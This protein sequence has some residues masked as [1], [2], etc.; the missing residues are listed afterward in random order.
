MNITEYPAT[1]TQEDLDLG[2]PRHCFRC[3]F[4]LAVRRDVPGV[5]YVG[6]GSISGWIKRD[7]KTVSFRLPPSVISSIA[8]IDS[9]R[10]HEV[11]VPFRFVV[12]VE[13]E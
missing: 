4:A 8:L 7:E 13:G 12:R 10:A 1:L 11:K 3:A 5:K 9:G 2:Q 6:V